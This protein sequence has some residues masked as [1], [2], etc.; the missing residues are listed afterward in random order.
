MLVL[1]GILLFFSAA[2]RVMQWKHVPMA[3]EI[4]D[5]TITWWWMA[6]VFFLALATHRVVSFVFLGFLCFA[7]LREYFSLMPMRETVSERT[8]SF[9]D[10]VSIAIC[11]LSIPAIIAIA[12]V[13]WY[14]L[15]I[16]LIPVYVLLLVPI[17]FVLQDR[18]QGSLKSMAIIALGLLFFVHNLGHCLFMINL[19][20]IV[21]MTC[22]TL[23]EV[24]DLLS[25][26]VG[27]AFAALSSR[28][29]D[30]T[31]KHI[32]EKRIAP[33]VSPKKT[34][35][36]G[37]VSAG[38]IAAA[39]LVFVPLMPAFPDGKLTY[40]YGAFVGFMIG[41]VG[42]F[43]DLVFSMIKRD[44]GIKDSGS[45]LPGHGGIIDRVDSLV[46]TIPVVFHL[47]FWRYF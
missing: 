32:L 10:R 24:R 5:R 3:D 18:T 12:Y 16:I 44:L 33:A 29:K 14:E 13:E 2:W 35:C 38:L 15:F 11:Y 36:A 20:A 8:L 42:L 19:G 6:A 30:G 40:A 46:F 41:L 45:T 34:W 4:R 43:G 22:F 17:V 39:A 21:L 23:T 47:I 28:L 7:S 37:I 27:K 25:F 1:L 9:R 26:W 31:L